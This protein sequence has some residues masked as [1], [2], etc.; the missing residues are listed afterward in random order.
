MS[1]RV[2]ASRAQEPGRRGGGWEPSRVDYRDRVVVLCLLAG[3][4][5][6]LAVFRPWH[7]AVPHQR[8]HPGTVANVARSADVMAGLMLVLL[9]RELRRRKPRAWQA[10]LACWR[11]T[12]SSMSRTGCAGPPRVAYAAVAGGFFVYA[13]RITRLTE[14]GRHR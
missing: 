7:G 1:P 8:L 4:S 11:S 6:A 10:V 12:S 3:L 13:R 5:D 9:S 14:S 2:H